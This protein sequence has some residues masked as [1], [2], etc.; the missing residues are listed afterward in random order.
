MHARA[1]PLKPNDLRTGRSAEALRTAPMLDTALES[2]GLALN[3][4]CRAPV[5]A[6]AGHA[7]AT[8]VLRTSLQRRL[9]HTGHAS[10]EPQSRLASKAA[11][12]W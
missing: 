7:G 10:P 6:P 12:D 11:G 8:R 4:P 1:E 5:Q 9:H 2:P 3:M